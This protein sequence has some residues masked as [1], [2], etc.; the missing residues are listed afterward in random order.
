MK[1]EFTAS[2]YI[3]DGAKVLLVLHKK[4]KKWLPVGGHV[5]LNET[6]EEAAKREAK[7]E[8]GIDVELIPQENITVNHPNARSFARPYLCLLQEIPPFGSQEHH[9]HIDFVFVAK[10]Q[11]GSKHEAPQEVVRWFTLEELRA[12]SHEELFLETKEILEH[13]FTTRCLTGVL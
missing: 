4:L 9:Q 5:E 11:E 8:A 12:L 1:K 3:F 7:E 6:P 13:L 10:P 2:T